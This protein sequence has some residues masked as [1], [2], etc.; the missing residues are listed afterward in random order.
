MQ[1]SLKGVFHIR[2]QS[3]Q[4]LTSFSSGTFVRLQIF[5]CYTSTYTC[6]H[7]IHTYKNTGVWGLVR[8]LRVWL[9]CQGFILCVG[10]GVRGLVGVSGV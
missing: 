7:D 1:N 5:K 9:G 2:K 4:M 10:G 3:I 6:V 8:G